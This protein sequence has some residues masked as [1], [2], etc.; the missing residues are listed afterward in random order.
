VNIK[1]LINKLLGRKTL[2]EQLCQ[3]GLKVG[4]NFFMNTGSLIDFSHCW[5]IEIGDNVTFAPYVTIL[6]HDAS[7]KLHTGYTRIAPVKIGDRVF[8]GAGSIIMPGVVIGN[9]AIIGAGSIVTKDIPDGS[10]AVGSPARVISS[11]EDYIKKQMTSI[12]DYNKFDESF[13]LRGRIDEKKRQ[14]MLLFFE[15][16]SFGYVE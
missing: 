3:N 5:L 14:E 8:I 12:T 6:A 4:N 16:N 7:T 13:T 10:L 11:T 15:N 2:M 1:Q 9:D